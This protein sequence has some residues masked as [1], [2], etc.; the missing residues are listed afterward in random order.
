VNQA[1]H[2]DGWIVVLEMSDPSE[3]NDLLDAAAYEALLA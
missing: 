3:A 2:A 1:P